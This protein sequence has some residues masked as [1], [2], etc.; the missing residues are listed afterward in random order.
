MH[1]LR[2]LFDLAHWHGL[3]KLHLHTDTTLALFSQVTASLGNRLHAFEE[4]TCRIHPTQELE[5]EQA[6]QV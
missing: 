1:V 4:K 3:V 6:A 2:V 5:H